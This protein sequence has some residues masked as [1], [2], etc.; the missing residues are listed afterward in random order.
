MYLMP[1]GGQYDWNM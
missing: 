1:G